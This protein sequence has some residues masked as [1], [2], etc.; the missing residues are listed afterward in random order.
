MVRSQR[1]RAGLSLAELE[2]RSGVK[3]R[4]LYRIESGEVTRPRMATLRALALALDVEIE[5]LLPQEAA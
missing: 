3:V 5:Q 2:E 1:I 4:Q